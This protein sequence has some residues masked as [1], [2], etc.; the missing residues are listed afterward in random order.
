M[1]NSCVPS[2]YSFFC[3]SSLISSG[4][5]SAAQLSSARPPSSSF[6]SLVCA[7][8]LNTICSPSC[9]WW[10]HCEQS[11]PSA[12]PSR[13]SHAWSRVTNSNNL[14]AEREH[15]QHRIL[16]WKV[17]GACQVALKYGKQR[18]V[19]SLLPQQCSNLSQRRFPTSI[20]T[21]SCTTGN[22]MRMPQLMSILSFK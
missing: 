17:C 18:S 8:Q 6:L 1:K 16:H 4:A 21:L 2:K 14:S 9:V 10:P 3:S 12:L 22:P 15:C 11:A 20:D 7:G 5:S 13:C 19:A